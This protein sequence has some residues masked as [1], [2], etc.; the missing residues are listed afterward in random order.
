MSV[1]YDLICKECKK[2]LWIG[3]TTRC[4]YSGEP[5]TMAALKDFLFD[6]TAHLLTFEP[7]EWWDEIPEGWEEIDADKYKVPPTQVKEE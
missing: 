4:F 3:Q 7:M 6:H 1:T 2:S 5:H